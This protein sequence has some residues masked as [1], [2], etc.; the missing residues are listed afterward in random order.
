MKTPMVVLLAALLTLV[1]CK[2][3]K[4]KVKVVAP[5]TKTFPAINWKRNMNG[6]VVIAGESRKRL[7][8]VEFDD[9]KMPVSLSAYNKDSGRRTWTKE[10]E[11]A[12]ANPLDGRSFSVVVKGAAVAAWTKANKIVAV[13]RFR[14]V[15]LWDKPVDGMGLAILG[16]NF[17]TSF[18]TSIRL[19][20]PE[21]GKK[22]DFNVGRKITQPVHVTPKGYV[23]VVTGD[24][25]R[26]VDLEGDK[27]TVR[28]TWI[29]DMDK[30]FEPGQLLSTD[31]AAIFF[32]R[33]HDQE[34]Q[35]WFK[36]YAGATIKQDWKLKLKGSESKPQTFRRFQEGNLARFVYIP[37]TSVE[38]QWRLID[39]EKGTSF[40][41]TLYSKVD[42][43]RHCL[44][45]KT[46]S[47]CADENGI[48]A[49]ETATWKKKWFQETILPVNDNE[50][51]IIDG[52]L[53][54]AAVNRIKVFSPSGASP[55]ALDL[56]SPTIKEPRVNKIL[57]GKDGIVYFTVADL[58]NASRTKGEVWALDMKTK[59]IKWRVN[60]GESRT[61]FE[62]VTYLPELDKI[63]AGNNVKIVSIALPSGTPNVTYHKIRTPKTAKVSVGA[64]GDMGYIALPDAVQFFKI[65]KNRL[66]MKKK[67]P[68]VKTE[69]PKK[70]GEKPVVTTFSFVGVGHNQVFIKDPASQIVARDIETGKLLYS[71]TFPTILEPKVLTTTSLVVLH[72]FGSA[73]AMDPKTGKVLKEFKDVRRMFA[74]GDG[75]TVVSQVLS[76]PAYGARLITFSFE[77][78]KGAPKL[79]WKKV[80]KAPVEKPLPGFSAHYPR[81][82]ATGKEYVMYPEK[83]GRCLK[84]VA[85]VDGEKV[86]ELCKSV[87]PWAP[88]VY[89]GKYYHAT[90]EAVTGVPESQQGLVRFALNGSFK[91]LLKMSRS[92]D[93]RYLNAQACPIKKGTLYLQ[94]SGEALQA[95]QVDE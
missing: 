4:P 58:A 69:K 87:W 26:L 80:F 19:I 35:L 59:K 5:P 62:A 65:T 67:F 95:I 38:K 88:S 81:W 89:H 60:V 64:M 72:S 53:V 40:G 63:L 20:D 56:K 27:V 7:F 2:A 32:Q 77:N 82:V 33:T 74:S 49:Y 43:P 78:T 48:T 12:L 30:G 16:E 68:L 10:L 66:V 1:S 90:G 25:A 36:H 9:K 54:L 85:S 23:V 57:G 86:L 3:P 15:D 42:P 76:K 51:R 22:T 79:M 47:Y 91:Q 8:G 11:L 6:A 71:T 24:E 83:G 92:G 21:S 39:L 44:L 31:D 18:D 29:I 45:D 41:K 93:P 61:I 70:R 84:V 50:H 52:N 14:G 17:I 94:G 46:I 13:D 34:N 55:L 37:E 28:W 73:R 75:F